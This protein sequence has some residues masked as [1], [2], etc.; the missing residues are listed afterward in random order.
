MPSIECLYTQRLVLRRP[1]AEDA[2]EIFRRYGADPEVTRFVSFSTHRSLEDTEA[3]LSMSD[4][5]WNR[6][7]AGPFLIRSKESAK[8]LG[9]TGLSFETLTRA[10]TGYVLAKDVWGMGYATESLR[11]M[12]DL[13]ARLQV[14]RVYALCHTEHR[15]SWRVLEKCGFQREGT[16]RRFQNFP[17]LITEELSD[18][19][20]YAIIL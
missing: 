5:A 17:N 19:Y 16:L 7:P 2:G 8:L 12:V 10:M 20:C 15:A 4:A 6:W 14:R 13:A 9:G 1:H 3:F 11:A 18:V